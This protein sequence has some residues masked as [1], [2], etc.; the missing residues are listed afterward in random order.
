MSKL[1]SFEKHN[2]TATIN[3]PNNIEFDFDVCSPK[4]LPALMRLINNSYP[5]WESLVIAVSKVRQR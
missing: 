3:L 5:E 4:S 2:L 1:S